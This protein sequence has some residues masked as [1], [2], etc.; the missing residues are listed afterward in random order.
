VRAF[1]SISRLEHEWSPAIA[2]SAAQSMHEG[3]VP[4]S[5]SPPL[6]HRRCSSPTRA[7]CHRRSNT[8]RCSCTQP[9]CGQ[10]GQVPVLGIDPGPGRVGQHPEDQ[11]GKQPQLPCGECRLHGSAP[12]CLRHV[13]GIRAAAGTSPRTVT[14][15]R[16]PKRSKS[17]RGPG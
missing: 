17:I 2:L 10:Q 9:L 8:A 5:L 3:A 14:R 12:V 1:S 13:A 11:H 7:S 4:C 6:A 15:K 16:S